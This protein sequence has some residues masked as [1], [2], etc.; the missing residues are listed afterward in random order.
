MDPRSMTSEDFTPPNPSRERAHREYAALFRI[1]ERHGATPEQRARQSH[2]ESWNPWVPSGSWPRWRAAFTP[3]SPANR[4]S[5]T[6]T[7]PR[8]R[9]VP[10]GS[11]GDGPA[12]GAVP[13]HRSPARND[14]AGNRIRVGTRQHPSGAAAIRETGRTHLRSNTCRARSRR[15]ASGLHESAG[16]RPHSLDEQRGERPEGCDQTGESP[17]RFR[18]C[19]N[20]IEVDRTQSRSELLRTHCLPLCSR[21]A[22]ASSQSPFSAPLHV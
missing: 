11:R 16:S 21:E 9:T 20:L 5:T 7:S 17:H 22:G 12:R 2:P 3:P 10:Q 15:A 13:R 8:P 19:D 14:L 4:M 6:P 18:T 1:I